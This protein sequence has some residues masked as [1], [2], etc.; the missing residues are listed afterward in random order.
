MKDGPFALKNSWTSPASASAGGAQPEYGSEG[1]AEAGR[2]PGLGNRT[3]CHPGL[4]LGSRKT[5]SRPNV[6]PG[7]QT[8][9][10]FR[11]G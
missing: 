11:P 9:A 6:C 3:V 4:E 2:N 8:S 7:P 10:S 1:E 5:G